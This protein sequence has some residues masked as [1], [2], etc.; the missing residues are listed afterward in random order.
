MSKKIY[1][2]TEDR[3][4]K[5]LK[6]E[7]LIKEKADILTVVTEKGEKHYSITV[8][9]KDTSVHIRNLIENLKISK[10]QNKKQERKIKQLGQNIDELKQEII[11]IVEEQKNPSLKERFS[12]AFKI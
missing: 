12:K 2:V 1:Q 9:N 3:F 6:C 11:K 7:S 8:M 4:N 5:L 10:A